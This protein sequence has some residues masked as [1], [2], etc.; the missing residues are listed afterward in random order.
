MT[1]DKGRIVSAP[2]QWAAGDELCISEC[3]CG[4]GLSVEVKRYDPPSYFIDKGNP[5]SVTIYPCPE[6]EADE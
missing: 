2:L 6:G 3:K 1:T 4:G 5:V